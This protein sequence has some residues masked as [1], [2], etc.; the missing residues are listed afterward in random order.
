MK[1]LISSVLCY[2][3]IPDSCMAFLR[4]KIR[5]KV[6]HELCS[7]AREVVCYGGPLAD[8][9]THD[10]YQTWRNYEMLQKKALMCQT[11]L[12]HFHIYLVSPLRPLQEYRTNRR[13]ALYCKE[14]TQ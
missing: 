13:H 1:V 14:I 8:S 7:R 4:S 3:S 12:C 6:I 5:I 11:R 9:I 2:V 10:I